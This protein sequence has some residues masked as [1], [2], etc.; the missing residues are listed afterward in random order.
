VLP[1]IEV[2]VDLVNWAIHPVHTLVNPAGIITITDY[3]ATEA[4]RRFY[5]ARLP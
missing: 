3:T 5:R 1:M 4:Q 2:S